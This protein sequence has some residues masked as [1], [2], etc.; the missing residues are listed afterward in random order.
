[1]LVYVHVEE[2]RCWCLWWRSIR[3]GSCDI[4]H[5]NSGG[6]LRNLGIGF[7]AAGEAQKSLIVDSDNGFDTLNKR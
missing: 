1:M 4:R 3:G 5:F 2:W 7:L 6:F